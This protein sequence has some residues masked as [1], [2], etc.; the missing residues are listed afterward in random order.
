MKKLR[1]TGPY[2]RRHET[3][4]H[5]EDYGYLNMDEDNVHQEERHGSSKIL[6]NMNEMAFVTH[7]EN[8]LPPKPVR[9]VRWEA[10]TLGT[11]KINVDG[12]S[13]G[14][15]GKLGYAG[16]SEI[17]MVNGSLD[18]RLPI[19]Q[20]FTL[21]NWGKNRSS[22]VRFSYW[23][24]PGT[25]WKKLGSKINSYA[26]GRKSVCRLSYETWIKKQQRLKLS[27]HLFGWTN[28]AVL[29]DHMAFVTH[30]ENI[31]PPKPVRLVRW[32]APTLG[33]V[34]INVDGS[35]L[36]NP[37]KAGIGGLIRDSDGEWIIGF[38]ASIGFNKILYAEL[39]AIKYGLELAWER[40][41]PKVICESDSTDAIQLVEWA[42]IEVHMY[43]SLIGEIRELLERNWEARLI[44]TLR[45]GNQ[46]ADYL[47]KLGSR[48]NNGCYIWNSPLPALYVQ[49]S[50]DAVGVMYS[51][52]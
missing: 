41:C 19:Q 28:S 1:I 10:P 43:G 47:A 40:Q 48:S 20:D 25:T 27:L 37:G 45:E 21:F 30:T 42:K 24:N 9:L 39:L 36:G 12:S 44:H 33:T 7:T 4:Q 22:Y 13:L 11:V 38:T 15:P 50:R 16:L 3:E 46:C 2:S 32:E 29:L 26:E 18:S 14:N 49:L 17:Q 8:I 52:K 5:Q 6:K 51:R 35:S 34:K 31:L 23:R